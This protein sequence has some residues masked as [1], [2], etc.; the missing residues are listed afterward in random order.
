MKKILAISLIIAMTACSVMG[1]AAEKEQASSGTTVSETPDS[2][3]NTDEP[4]IIGCETSLTGEKALTGEYMKNALDLAVERINA[5]GGLLGREVQVILEDDQGTD[6]GAVNAYNKLASSGSCAII[7]NLYS[8]MNVA[9]SGEAEKAMLPT[10]VTGSSVSVSELNNPYVFQARTNDDIAVR[11]I[12]NTAVND[13]GYQNI[14]IIH[15]SD[16][17]GQG[18]YEVA[19]STLEE[20]GMEPVVVTTYN[21]GDKDFTAHI[22][23][24]QH[25]NA[26]VIIAFG[27][28][29]EAGLI[30][31]QLDVMDNQLPI[32]GSTSYASA[33]AI[34]LAGEA[35]NGVYSVVD[36]VPTTPLEA[37]QEFAELY[38]NEY[39]IESDWSGAAAWDSFLIIT[40][41][42]RRAGTTD[43]DA[44]C[45]EIS[46]LTDFEGASNIF[47][48]DENHVGGTMNVFVQ[49]EDL[50][51]EVLGT[52]SAR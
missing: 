31:K 32:I 16:A 25:S 40:E 44:V 49:I 29:T 18:A 38:R 48:F 22:S 37:G 4:I 10:V 11:A 12:I 43:A 50:T 8:T 52:A 14:A 6:Q 33:I 41:A 30:M 27:L 2:G 15:D 1:C 51:P 35:A 36:Y 3:E 9:I 17:Y 20:M 45:Q 13:M 24:I 21:S 46:N 34:D 5:E 7:G 23:Q 28:Q 19:V 26:D 39:G 42:I 47:S